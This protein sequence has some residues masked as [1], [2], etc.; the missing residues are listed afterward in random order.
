MRVSVVPIDKAICVDG[1]PALLT[2]WPFAD[3]GI[4]AIQWH[5]TEGEIEY[6]FD[7]LGQEPRRV[8]EVIT[9][10]SIVQPYVDAH[11]AFVIAEKAA[12]DKAAAD[13][14]A[15]EKAAAEQWAAPKA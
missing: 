2:E 14:A 10:A 6:P 8:N 15:A 13:M 11:T 3:S 7:P 1:V 4:H 5:G 9:D 12:A